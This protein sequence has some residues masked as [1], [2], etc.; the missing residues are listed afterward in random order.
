MCVDLGLS[1]SVIR[2]MDANGDGFIS[3]AEFKTYLKQRRQEAAA[4]AAAAPE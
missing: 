4:A 3:L 1:T 2:E